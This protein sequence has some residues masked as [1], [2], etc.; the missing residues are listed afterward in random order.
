MEKPTVVPEDLLELVLK[1]VLNVSDVIRT[2]KLS[3]ILDS[4][5]D[6]QNNDVYTIQNTENKQ[7]RGVVLDLDYFLE[8]IF[9]K[10]LVEES[11]DAIVDQAALEQ[12]K[13]AA[14]VK[15]EEAVEQLKHNVDD[16]ADIMKIAE[17]EL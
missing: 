5:A 4:Y 12:F 17:I 2:A 15:L 13:Q 6:K 10:R 1:N 14:A 9:I 8:L 11:A 7:A 16:F 3:E